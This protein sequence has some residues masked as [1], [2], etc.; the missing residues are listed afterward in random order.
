MTRT[1]AEQTA[2]VGQI[3]ADLQA[4]QDAN[5][6]IVYEIRSDPERPDVP[7]KLTFDG[8]DEILA[9]DDPWTMAWKTADI[10]SGQLATHL[11][12]F[13][14]RIFTDLRGR[15]TRRE[16]SYVVTSCGGSQHWA[17]SDKYRTLH[18][19]GSGGFCWTCLHPDR[20]L[21]QERHGLDPPPG[22]LRRTRPARLQVL[23]LRRCG[24]R[25]GPRPR[26]RRSH[27]H[28]GRGDAPSLRALRT[29]LPDGHARGH[30]LRAARP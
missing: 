10:L 23:R 14:V 21:D 4:K 28:L 29:R 6:D 22:H 8:R 1:E 3:L 11:D 12:I 13:Q 18:Q 20:D 17:D 9:N 27:R 30:R 15:E 25:P 5:P 7:R 16:E 19:I 24:R 2:L 26:E